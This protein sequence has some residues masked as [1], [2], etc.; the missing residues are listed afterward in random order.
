[1]TNEISFLSSWNLIILN[2]YLCYKKLKTFAE[3]SIFLKDTEKWRLFPH[4]RSDRGLKGTVVN[5]KWPSLNGMSFEIIHIQ[6]LHLLHENELLGRFFTGRYVWMQI[7]YS[8]P[9]WIMQRLAPFD[10]AGSIFKGISI[11]TIL[12]RYICL[13][14]Y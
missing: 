1:M 11:K 6:Y 7:R 8:R 10:F 9:V 14:S 13:L 5:R 12:V 3:L 2:T 4:C